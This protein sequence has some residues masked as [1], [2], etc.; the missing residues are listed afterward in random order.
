MFAVL[1]IKESVARVSISSVNMTRPTHLYLHIWQVL[2][3]SGGFRGGRAGSGP[4]FGDGL[5]PS[6]YS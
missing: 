5:M 1:C 4:P 6:L 3:I 2:Y